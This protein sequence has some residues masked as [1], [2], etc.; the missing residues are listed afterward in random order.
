MPCLAVSETT[1]CP[2]RQALSVSDSA[3]RPALSGMSETTVL[4]LP[5]PTMSETTVLG[6]PCLAMS[7]TTVLGMPSLSMS[8][9]TV[10]RDAPSGNV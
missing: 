3:S 6:V 1:A 2:V 5:C 7:E 8:E 4:G 10:P 9:T